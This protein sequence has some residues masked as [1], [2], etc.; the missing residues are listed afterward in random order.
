MRLIGKGRCRFVKDN[1]LIVKSDITAMFALALRYVNL[2]Y[3]REGILNAQEI[4]K[5]DC[6]KPYGRYNDRTN[7]C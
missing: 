4:F 2:Y 7:C 1:Y 5:S 3:I 6:C